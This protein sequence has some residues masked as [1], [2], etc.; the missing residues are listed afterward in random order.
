MNTKIISDHIY[1][2]NIAKDFVELHKNA[3]LDNWD[4]YYPPAPAKILNKREKLEA[5]YQNLSDG[6]YGEIRKT[7]ANT[8][9]VEIPARQSRTA[10]PIIFEFTK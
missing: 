8:Y 2:T 9:E 10:L 6:E 1:K 7:H 5:I 3:N 4:P